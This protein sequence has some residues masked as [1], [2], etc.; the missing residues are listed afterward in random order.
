MYDNLKQP[1]NFCCPCQVSYSSQRPSHYQTG[2][3]LTRYIDWLFEIPFHG[4]F[5]ESRFC[6]GF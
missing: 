3:R 2:Y 5:L 6:F 1:E 4:R